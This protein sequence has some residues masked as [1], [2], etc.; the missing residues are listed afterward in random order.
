MRK[1]ERT[2]QGRRLAESLRQAAKIAEGDERL[3]VRG[4]PAVLPGENTGFKEG[5]EAER[6]YRENICPNGGAHP[7]GPY[8]PSP[9]RG[10]SL[11]GRDELVRF[12]PHL[13]IL[14]AEMNPDMSRF[15]IIWLKAS[16]ARQTV[17]K[18]WRRTWKIG[19][20]IIVAAFACARWGVEQIPFL[21]EIAS[22]IR[23]HGL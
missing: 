23:G 10:I 8:I 14:F 16:V 17:G 15:L 22:I 6:H 2:E 1:P 3:E 5:I 4:G 19:V 13:Q 21:K 9:D 12:P 11:Q 20:A 18:W 7:L